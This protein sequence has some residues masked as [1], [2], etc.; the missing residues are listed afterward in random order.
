MCTERPFDPTSKTTSNQTQ[1]GCTCFGSER[2][3]FADEEGLTPKRRYFGS[4]TGSCTIGPRDSVVSI[5]EHTKK[6]ILV[7]PRMVDSLRASNGPPVPGAAPHSLLEVDREM[8]NALEGN[9][10]DFQDKA[11]LY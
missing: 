11:Q 3:V 4:P 2:K 9:D 8:Q 10:V 5:M 7:D 1:T 6:M